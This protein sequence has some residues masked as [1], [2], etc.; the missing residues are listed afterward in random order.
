MVSLMDCDCF[1]LRVVLSLIVLRLVL[2]SW[3]IDVVV[4]LIEVWFNYCEYWIVIN[5]ILIFNEKMSGIVW[6]WRK[7]LIVGRFKL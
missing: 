6:C 2:R 5:W 4:L 7:I 1:V 3:M